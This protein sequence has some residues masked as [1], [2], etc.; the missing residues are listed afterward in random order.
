M[1]GIDEISHQFGMIFER[2]LGSIQSHNH[3]RCG[4]GIRFGA[5]LGK[6]GGREDVV[7]NR[8]SRLGVDGMGV[9][10]AVLVV[11]VAVVAACSH[12]HILDVEH[13]LQLFVDCKRVVSGLRYANLPRQTLLRYA[14]GYNL[15]ANLN[16][17]VLDAVALEQ[18]CHNVAT[19]TFGNGRAVEHNARVGLGYAVVAQ[20]HLLISYDRAQRVDS[21]L[22]GRV[23]SLESEAPCVDKRSHRYVEGTV[24]VVGNVLGQVEH[25]VEHLVG[26][27]VLSTVDARY[28][29][30]VV[31]HRQGAVYLGKFGK[32]VVVQG[33]VVLVGYVVER[34]EHLTFVVLVRRAALLTHNKHGSY[35]EEHEEG[36]LPV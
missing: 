34:A 32:D 26:L 16:H 11:E 31:E 2:L 19:V 13:R 10:L 4:V 28:Y 35:D 9:L 23:A 17:I 14:V 20:R 18:V 7:L 30:L 1:V 21:R 25:R 22:C 15:A 33:C 6:H 29:R 3:K 8:V 36:Q 27:N 5:M 12:S 24:G